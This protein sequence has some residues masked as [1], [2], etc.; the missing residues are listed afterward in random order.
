LR[1]T[2]GR[3]SGGTAHNVIAETARL[4][5]TIR[6]T[7]AEVRKRIIAGLER[8]AHG[9]AELHRAQVKITNRE[10]YPPVINTPREVAWAREAAAAVVGPEGVAHQL[11]PSLGGE[12]F[13]FYLQKVPGCFVRFGAA[14]EGLE[15]VPAHSPRFDFDERVLPIGAAFLATVARKALQNL[16]GE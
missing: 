16:Q 4:E 9:V 12:D 3:F 10:G 14:K 1:V 11:H 2:V 15:G 13:A 6:S 8:M 7:H 5:G